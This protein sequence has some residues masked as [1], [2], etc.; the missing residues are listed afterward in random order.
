ME[1]WGTQGCPLVGDPT[2]TVQGRSH[3]AKLSVYDWN[4][5]RLPIL[6]PLYKT[7]YEIIKEMTSKE[8][9]W[10]G[11]TM[12]EFQP[13]SVPCTHRSHC[14]CQQRLHNPRQIHDATSAYHSN[15]RNL[16]ARAPE[17]TYFLMYNSFAKK[18][19]WHCWYEWWPYE[20]I[21]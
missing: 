17:Q 5:A 7:E 10:G 21:Y 9:D 4:N 1:I 16:P 11:N 2:R 14:L 6:I 15:T 3:G 13:K 20:M 8:V 18:N 19:G 12:Y